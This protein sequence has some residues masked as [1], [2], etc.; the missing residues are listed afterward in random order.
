[1]TF[2]APLMAGVLVGLAAMITSILG[3]LQALQLSG[4]DLGNLSNLLN[5]F[6][7]S[8]TIPPFYLQIAMGV[9]LI[10][11]IY[12]LTGTLVTIDSGE[13]PL[14]K[15]FLTGRNV[16]KG[17]GLYIVVATMSIIILAVLSGVVLGGLG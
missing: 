9:Y 7:V 15:T 11:I 16:L 4:N 6:D 17:I 13:D 8:Q 12:I 14:Q 10:Q 3:R 5:I 1:M 2:I